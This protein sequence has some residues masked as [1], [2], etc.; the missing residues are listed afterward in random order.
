MR[1]IPANEMAA[2]RVLVIGFAVQ[3]AAIAMLGFDLEGIVLI[4][5]VAALALLAVGS[6][7]LAR[8]TGQRAGWAALA[9]FV[10]AGAALLGLGAMYLANDA[11][12]GAAVWFAYSVVLFAFAGGVGV[13]AGRAGRLW[14]ALGVLAALGQ[15]LLLPAPPFLERLLLRVEDWLYVGHALRAF[16]LQFAVA[17]AAVAGAIAPFDGKVG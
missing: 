15:F 8:R 9:L 13:L 11:S 1:E 6:G 12:P 16:A 2:V 3:L 10:L 17:V 5:F 7:L 4:A 14:I